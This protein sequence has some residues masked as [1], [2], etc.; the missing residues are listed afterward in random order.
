MK[1]QTILLALMLVACL[2]ASAQKKFSAYGV[3]FYNLENLFD[4]IHDEGKND[5]EF[6]PEGS[7]KWNEMKYT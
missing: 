3:G 4:L 6:L 5:Y 7:Y 1:K 2:S